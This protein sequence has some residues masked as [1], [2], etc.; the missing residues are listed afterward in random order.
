V[1]KIIRPR[2]GVASLELGELWR[3]RELVYFFA[4]RD[5][6]VRY[7]Q[8]VIG[9]AWAFVRPLLTTVVLVIIFGK[10]AK[11]PSGELPYPVV[12]LA[13][14][15][16][17]Q[18]FASAFGDASGS[19]VGG[20]QLVS[21]VYFP[22]LI[23]PISAVVSAIVDSLITMIM[24]AALLVW[25]RIPLSVNVVW[26]PFLVLLC[27]AVALA[28]GIWFSALFVRYRDVRHLL[29]FIVQ[30][31]LY[32]SPVGFSSAV[33]PERWRA[34]YSLNPMVGVIDGF[35]WALFGGRNPLYLPGLASSAVLT[36]VLLIA[37]LYYFR[38]TERLFAD[39]I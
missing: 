21:R 13:G 18:L 4:W 26:V 37:A 24:L 8:T 29:P 22:R 20:S 1:H 12:A 25:Y 9:V 17:W 27:I 30:I 3:Y 11:L 34:L 39:V 28:G 38:T 23:L 5:I 33:V 7:K 6:L 31:G 35:R 15:A 36:L 14:V 16:M 10:I 19:V 2:K 32:L